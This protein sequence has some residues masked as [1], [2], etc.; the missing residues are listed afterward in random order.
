MIIFIIVFNS[1]VAFGEND[2]EKMINAITRNDAHYVKKLLKDGVAPN[3]RI[4]S[5]GNG[6]DWGHILS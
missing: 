4:D 2:F 3:M 5:R 1:L 6:E